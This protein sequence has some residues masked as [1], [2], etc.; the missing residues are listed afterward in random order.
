MK[1][2]RGITLLAASMAAMSA[3]MQY[4]AGAVGD[5]KAL[6]NPRPEWKRKKCKSCLAYQ[7]YI[8][9]GMCAFPNNNAC[10]YYKKQKK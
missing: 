5:F 2:L 3:N 7:K 10:K 9:Y 4:G 6:I 1:N 8:N